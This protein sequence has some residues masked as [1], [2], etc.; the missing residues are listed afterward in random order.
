[1]AASDHDLLIEL[2]VKM[3]TLHGCFTDHLETS[4]KIHS[5]QCERLNIL[6]QWKW[7]WAGAISLLVLILTFIGNVAARALVR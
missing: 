4:E 6:E 2:N 7:K 1:M 3:D 5:R